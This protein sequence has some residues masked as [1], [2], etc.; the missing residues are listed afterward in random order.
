MQALGR[1]SATFASSPEPKVDAELRRRPAEPIDHVGMVGN[2]PFA[3]LL[4][5]LVLRQTGVED[6]LLAGGG[7]RLAKTA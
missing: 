1:V 4:L 3:P 7:A 5:H 2:S 6:A